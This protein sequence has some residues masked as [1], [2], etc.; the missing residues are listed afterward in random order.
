MQHRPEQEMM[1]FSLSE[2]Y[3]LPLFS[4][5]AYPAATLSL[6]YLYQK[7]VAI[8]V[9]DLTGE[10]FALVVEATGRLMDP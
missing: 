5:L 4:Q 6:H 2:T 9:A 7:S 3:Y 10:V 1:T 8:L